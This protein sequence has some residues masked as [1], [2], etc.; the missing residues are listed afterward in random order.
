MGGFWIQ[1]HTFLLLLPE[2]EKS[3]ATKC[4]PGGCWVEEEEG[5]TAGSR[6]GLPVPQETV[7]LMGELG[8]GRAVPG[9]LSGGGV[10]DSG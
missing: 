7:G 5:A 2:R 1:V 8:A 9:A 6:A 3:P 10:L 4:N